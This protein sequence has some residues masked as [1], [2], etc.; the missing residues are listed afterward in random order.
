MKLE[1][2]P[3]SKPD[4]LNVIIGQ[5]HFI[6]TIEDLYEALVNNVPSIKCG[7]AFCEA[8]GATLIRVEG[9]DEELKDIAVENAKNIAAGH[10]FFIALKDAY[11]INVLNQIKMVPEVCR[12]FCATANC[13]EVIVAGTGQGRGI[14]GVIDGHS[15]QGVED[16]AGVKWRK[17]L[18]RKIRYKL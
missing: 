9:N 14:L 11:P 17:D 5:A 10:S 18:L 7:I 12:I 2:V 16:A 6:K 4:D 15:P 13:L 1:I 3:V 8:S